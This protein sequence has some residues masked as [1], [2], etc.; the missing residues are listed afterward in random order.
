M[1]AANSAL[2][3]TANKRDRRHATQCHNL[4]TPGVAAS[5]IGGRLYPRLASPAHTAG[6]GTAD[7]SV[8]WRA[9]RKPGMRHER[10][11]E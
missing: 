10:A 11:S 5:E 7:G 3:P 6:A 4:G 1:G 9:G 8:L 2:L